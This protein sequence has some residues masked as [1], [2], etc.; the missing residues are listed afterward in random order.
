LR[1]QSAGVSSRCPSTAR[2]LG[3]DFPKGRSES[4]RQQPCRRTSSGSR[5]KELVRPWGPS[6]QIGSVNYLWVSVA[7]S[8]QGGQQGG[9]ASVCVVSAGAAGWGRELMLDGRCRDECTGTIAEEAEAQRRKKRGPR[10][11]YLRHV[12]D[13]SGGTL[14]RW[15]TRLS[16][17]PGPA[18]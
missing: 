16:R 4:K 3:H 13:Q 15:R 18:H 12:D 11:S 9:S 7:L 1:C 6:G 8:C 14:Y 5:D 17:K 2:Y 10:E